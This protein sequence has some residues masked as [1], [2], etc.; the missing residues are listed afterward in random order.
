L[1]QVVHA[2][3]AALRFPVA[4]RAALHAELECELRLRQ[5]GGAT[6]QADALRGRAGGVGIVA[7]GAFRGCGQRHAIKINGVND[8]SP[9]LSS[10]DSPSRGGAL[11]TAVLKSLSGIWLSKL[12]FCTPRDTSLTRA[13]CPCSGPTTRR[14]SRPRGRAT[15][16]G[17]GR[18]GDLPRF[19]SNPGAH[20][21]LECAPFLCPRRD[22]RAAGP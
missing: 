17:S 7:H 8:N 10:C 22:L 6:G 16:V 2:G 21:P 5:S 12:A 18:L 15:G 4:D 20:S 13:T 1:A 11:G 19:S 14:S 3:L 9:S